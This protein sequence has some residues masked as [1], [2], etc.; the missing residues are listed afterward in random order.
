MRISVCLN[1]DKSPD[2]WSH[3]LL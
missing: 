3:F 2:I 1:S